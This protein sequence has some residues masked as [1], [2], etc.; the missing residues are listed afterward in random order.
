L[1]EVKDG[2]S[3]DANS[4]NWCGTP[5]LLSNREDLNT[6]RSSDED[7]AQKIKRVFRWFV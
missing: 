5:L 4:D 6:E 3:L 7:N 1:K 2:H